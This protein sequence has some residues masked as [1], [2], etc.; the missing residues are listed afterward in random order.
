[1]HQCVDPTSN[2]CVSCEF[3]VLVSLSITCVAQ[4]PGVFPHPVVTLVHTLR[5]E[6]MIE[7]PFCSQYCRIWR[8][9][10][11]RLASRQMTGRP[12][13]AACLSW[14]MR[15][16]MSSAEGTIARWWLSLMRKGS[17]KGA[18]RVLDPFCQLSMA[19]LSAYKPMQ[20]RQQEQEASR[21][22]LGCLKTQL[23][24]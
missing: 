20:D 17:A 15:L 7:I 10:A 19:I 9:C 2:G 22:W 5:I 13:C 3:R 21:P 8:P 14:Q 23:P 12:A 16:A 1:M 6:L 24:L 18:C 4:D 11:E